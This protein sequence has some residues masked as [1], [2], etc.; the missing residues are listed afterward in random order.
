[1]KYGSEMLSI[2]EGALEGNAKKVRAYVELL[3][4]KLPVGDHMRRAIEKRL[5]GSY[6]NDAVLELKKPGYFCSLCKQHHQGESRIGKRH[7]EWKT[8]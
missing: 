3:Y 1:M 8:S 2:I 4:Q 7:L 5:D 6:K